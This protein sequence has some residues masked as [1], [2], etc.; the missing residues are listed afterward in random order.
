MTAEQNPGRTRPASGTEAPITAPPGTGAPSDARPSGLAALATVGV[1][2]WPVAA[3][4]G[5]GSYVAER[6]ARDDAR[7]AGQQRS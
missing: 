6:W 1:I 3:V 4:V 2:E 7:R 5:A